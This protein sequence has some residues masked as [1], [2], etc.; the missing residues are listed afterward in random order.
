MDAASYWTLTG[1]LSQAF[2]LSHTVCYFLS[3]SRR[4]SLLA[5]WF[6]GLQDQLTV[7]VKTVKKL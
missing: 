1:P 6:P 3:F 7:T 2:G 5:L 4:A